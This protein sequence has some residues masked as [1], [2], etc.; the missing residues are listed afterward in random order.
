MD[1][2]ESGRHYNAVETPDRALTTHSARIE[3]DHYSEKVVRRTLLQ[4][5]MQ[6]SFGI[7]ADYDF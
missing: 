5:K 4:I 6:E 2:S 3:G 7:I 1:F